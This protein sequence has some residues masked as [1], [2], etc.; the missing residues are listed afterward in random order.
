MR[1]LIMAIVFIMCLFPAQISKSSHTTR[2]VNCQLDNWGYPVFEVF[3]KGVRVYLSE[4]IDD[5][6]G[7]GIFCMLEPGSAILNLGTPKL[8]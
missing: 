8:L 6:E 4:F 3:D 1:R 7:K 2:A 5:D